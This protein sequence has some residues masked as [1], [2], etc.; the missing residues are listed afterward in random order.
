MPDEHVHPVLFSRS[1]AIA[2]SPRSHSTI[3]WSGTPKLVF[4]TVL[5][6]NCI[7]WSQSRYA[8]VGTRSPLFAP[9]HA[10]RGLFDV[11]AFD[12]L[13]TLTSEVRLSL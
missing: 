11:S 12:P 8:Q 6:L 1:R 2:P 13:R 10:K 4:V 3:M 7:L 9:S 5:V